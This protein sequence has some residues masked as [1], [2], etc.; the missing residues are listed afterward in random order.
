M[1]NYNLNIRSQNFLLQNRLSLL[2]KT[3]SNIAKNW[4]SKLPLMPTQVE[5][6]NWLYKDCD[7]IAS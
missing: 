4:I 6:P 1:L 2:L 5:A 7:E 3:N